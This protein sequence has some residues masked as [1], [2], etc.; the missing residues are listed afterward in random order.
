[1]KRHVLDIIT[2]YIERNGYSPSYREIGL[3]VGPRSPSSVNRY[4]DILKDEGQLLTANQKAQT[5]TL[6]RRVELNDA[7]ECLQRIRLEVANGGVLFVDCSM[8]RREFDSCA[9]SFSGVVDASQ[10]KGKVSRVINC[11]VDSG[12]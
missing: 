1:M 3:A 7:D 5:F 2:E 4:V 10:L 12:A 6:A 9:V 8:V 11:R